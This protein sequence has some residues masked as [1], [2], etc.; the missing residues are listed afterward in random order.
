MILAFVIVLAILFFPLKVEK[1]EF[2]CNKNMNFAKAI[3]TI[4]IVVT[5]CVGYYDEQKDATFYVLNNIGFL[6][7]GI[8]YF[9]SGY[10]LVYSN[11]HKENY[12]KTFWRKKLLNVFVPFWVVNVIYLLFAVF[13]EGNSYGVVDIAKYILGIELICPTLWYVRSVFVFYL[14]FWCSCK[15]I[16][17]KKMQII[18][19]F[20]LS[21]VLN[22]FVRGVISLFIVGLIAAY[23][24]ADR[25]GKLVDKYFNRIII[26][27]ILIFVA[28]FGAYINMMFFEVP[29]INVTLTNVT[30]IYIITQS[31]FLLLCLL[32]PT[33]IKFESVAIKK[34]SLVTYEI[35]LLHRLAL[36]SL[37]YGNLI[38][39]VF[40]LL[41]VLLSAVL[42]MIYAKGKSMI[43]IKKTK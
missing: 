17:N 2:L 25:I 32:M 1:E 15:L 40:I 34:I 3:A 9:S 22:V 26:F 5:H 31:A 12:L 13:V 36:D 43:L 28:S 23:I 24:R 14:L 10:G 4:M 11:S 38:V 8:F 27:V 29:Y 37:K 21:S 16:P 39:E 7:V 19:L 6:G 35:Y 30:V 41:G 20:V 33:R 42:A 18:L